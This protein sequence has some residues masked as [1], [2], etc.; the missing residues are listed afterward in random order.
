MDGVSF[1]ATLNDAQAPQQRHSQYYELQ[2]NRGYINGG[3]KIVSL[4]PPTQAINLDNWMLFDLQADPTE[5][6]DLAATQPE[7]L[8]RL[9]AEFEVVARANHVYPIDNRDDRRAITLPPAELADASRPRDFFPEA[10]PVPGTVVSPLIADRNFTLRAR[11]DWQPGQEGVVVA[12]GDHF[13]G[14]VLFVMDGALHFT[15]QLWHRP[16][17]LAPI[18][19]VPGAQDFVLDYTALG[20][21]KGRGRFTL[22]GAVVLAG[23]DLSPTLVRLPSGGLSVGLNRRRAISARY[24]D[25]GSFRYGGRIEVVRIEPG[26]QPADTP[27]LLDEAAVQAQ[28]RAAAAAADLID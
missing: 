21:R 25:R 15:Y 4:Q 8:R 23:A 16:T 18:P 26:P 1:A 7:V 14:M 5:I 17:E 10:D 19:L 11:F 3:W 24:A 27:M 2:G 6:H 12:L 9:V 20:G 28:I 22:N 13:L